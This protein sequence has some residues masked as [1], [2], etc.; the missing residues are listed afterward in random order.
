MRHAFGVLGVLAASV[1]LLVSG[2]MN[3]R[4]GYSLG[5][6]ELDSQLLGLAS[7]AADGL[8]ALIPFFLF[9]ALRN[10]QWSQ[11][12]AAGLLWV[13]CITYSFTSALGFSAL[14]RA[15]TA[16]SRI[17]QASTYQDVRSE[18]DKTRERLGWVP[19][20][21]PAL[22][23]SSEMDEVRQDRRWKATESCTNATKG[24]SISFCKN[25]HQLGAELAAAN[26]AEKLQVRI[27]ELRGQLQNASTAVAVASADPQSE[28]ISHLSGQDQEMVK[29]ALTVLVAILVELGSSL[30]YFVVFSTWKTVETRSTQANPVVTGT[31][32]ARSRVAAA[33]AAVPAAAVTANDNRQA[34]KLVAPESDVERF[35][36]ERITTSEGSSL[37]AT[38]L[39][40][41]YSDW[42]DEHGKEPMAL[43]TF[44]RAFGDL[45]VHKAKIAGRIRYIG[46]KLHSDT[47]DEEDQT[48]NTTTALTTTQQ[49]SASVLAA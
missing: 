48:P 2:A 49:S 17:V 12:L 8:K 26:E 13:I 30:G 45:G 27:D 46:I 43:P 44:G 25:F 14:N 20:H 5:H 3:W 22:T 32:V 4:F 7:A 10:K 6:S 34:P 31:V 21:R 38:T 41:D 33:P 36:K 18:L 37:T 23:V 9:A 39:Y 29:T 19:Q 16:G 35:Y 28:V 42:C 40:E 15:D 11:A 24:T 47:L 1:L